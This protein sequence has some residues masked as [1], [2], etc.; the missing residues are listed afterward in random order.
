M[1]SNADSIVVSTGQHDQYQDDN[2][3]FYLE[4]YKSLPEKDQPK[5]KKEWLNGIKKESKKVGKFSTDKIWPVSL[6]KR[7][8]FTDLKDFA[9]YMKSE[10]KLLNSNLNVKF[11]N[12]INGSF[13]EE[14]K[15]EDFAD[16]TINLIVSNILKENRLIISRVLETNVKKAFGEMPLMLQYVLNRNGRPL[17]ELQLTPVDMLEIIAENE[18]KRISDHI[19]IFPTTKK[20]T[21]DEKRGISTLKEIT[22][23]RHLW[24]YT[25]TVLFSYILQSKFNPNFKFYLGD[26]VPTARD[27]IALKRSGGSLDSDKED[28]V[29]QDVFYV[30][31]EENGIGLDGSFYKFTGT[32]DFDHSLYNETKRG[33]HENATKEDFLKILADGE[34]LEKRLLD[35]VKLKVAL[36]KQKL[37][38]LNCPLSREFQ[39]PSVVNMWKDMLNETKLDSINVH[40]LMVDI[41][42]L[43]EK[44]ELYLARIRISVEE[45]E[46]VGSN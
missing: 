33:R 45:S 46:V 1:E 27:T 21:L 40:D 2:T 8:G 37:D 14:L 25:G 34:I 42:K 12:Y 26:N 19:K 17:V 3:R 10:H 4:T 9:D 22:C 30:Q 32:S 6:S 35:N 38:I 18:S 20:L 44:I 28:D 13:K 43:Q 41:G 7:I 31:I 16:K 24:L 39:I 23:L 11:Y 36:E 5:Y 29:I 15:L